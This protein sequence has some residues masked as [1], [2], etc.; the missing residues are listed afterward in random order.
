VSG[1]TFDVRFWDIQ[2]RSDAQA[3][4][5]VRWKVAGRVF[6][7]SFVVK[8]L[9]DSFRAQLMEAARKGDS[10]DTE[11][12]LPLSI[13]RRDRDVSCYVHAQEFVK[14]AWPAAAGKSR[15]SILE[16]LSVALPA[17]ARDLTGEPD[18]DVLRLA[19]RRALNQ[20][21]H[22]RQPDNDERRALGWLERASLPVSSLDD[23][24]TV[25]DLLDVLGRKLDGTPAS[26]DYFSRRRRVMHRVLGYAVRKKRLAVNPLS[27]SNLPEGWSAP[28]APEDVVDPRSV[29]GPEQIADMLTVTS[30]VGSR[31]GPRFVA[32]YGCMFY[33]MM[34]PSEVASLVRDGCHLPLDGW[35]RLIFADASPAAGKDFTD[36]GRVHEA[37]GLKGRARQ[38]AARRATRNVPIPPELVGM[39]RAHI[40]RFGTTEDGR[41][42]RSENGNPIQPST[43]WQVWH[44][45]RALALT[46]A[47]LATP[48]MRRPYDLRHS[49]ITWRLNS[50]VPP[51]EIAAWA[52]HSVEMLLRVYARC[53]AGL[54]DVWIARMEATLR[55]ADD[56]EQDP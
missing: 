17:L 26:P 45:T 16:T 15:V 53:V 5:R 12:G 19:V 28:H 31:Q 37:R 41:L 8:A 44:K 14:A 10:F 49:G 51:T 54:E 50:G 55:P 56:H 34:R 23:P 32:F 29:G 30:Y 7:R 4:W 52:G 35:G 13:V 39:L 25:S 18:P 47:Q 38:S 43:Y 36:D 40:E 27:K 24:A 6:S 11:T 20:N 46:P 48:L 9:A 33:A 42:F 22:A 21:E 1:A 2:E 3:R